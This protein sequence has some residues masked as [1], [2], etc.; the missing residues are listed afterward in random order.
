MSEVQT[1]PNLQLLNDGY[2]VLG[3]LRS[4]AHARTY[5]AR[6]REDGSEVII[7]VAGAPKGGENNALNHFAADTQLLSKLSHPLMPKVIEGRWV[8]KD[9]FAVVSERHPGSTLDELLARGEKFSPPRIAGILQDVNTV[10]E[11]ARSNGVVHR[12]VSPD[13]LSFERDTNRVLL[14]L[15]PTAVPLEGVPDASA[16]ARTIGMLSWSMLAGKEFTEGQSLSEL[17]PNLAK[18]VVDETD[19][20]VRSTSGGTVPDV[21][22]YVAVVAAADALRSGELEIAE[23]QAQIAEERRAELAQFAAEQ[24]ASAL[25]NKEL[26]EQLANERR[27]FEAKMADEEA[28][29]AA[30][31]AEFAA[32]KASEESQ[33]SVERTQFE[34]ERLELEQARVAFEQK[35]AEREAELTAKHAAVDRLRAEEGKRIDAAIAAAV[36]TVAATAVITPVED[37]LSEAWKSGSGQAEPKA[38]VGET[39]RQ[40]S[41]GLG[42]QDVVTTGGNGRRP[43]WAMPAVAVA[44][45]LLLVG[46]FAAT[47][48]E[49][50]SPGAVAVGKST[51]VPTAPATNVRSTP[52]GGFMTQSAGGTVAAPPVGPPLAPQSTAQVTAAV[53]PNASIAPVG[54]AAAAGAAPG[55]AQTATPDSATLARQRNALAAGLVKPKPKPKASA[56]NAAADSTRG[57]SFSAEADAIRRADAARRDSA[58]RRDTTPRARPDTTVTAR[59]DTLLHR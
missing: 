44:L 32:L 6:R 55:T 38:W 4:G 1:A 52:Q 26:E 10:L 30:V 37:D 7:S 23:L 9:Q 42:E 27:E 39:V 24:Q 8:G 34:Q 19:S 53:Q 41:V 59:P 43:G 48:R 50:A 14:S 58:A 45:V 31:K 40:H 21:L 36:E 56:R 47:H 2:E 18:R 29:L 33:F 15:E 49:G 17:R 16:D 57:G 11:W 3:E 13:S 25:R 51:I 54:A 35:V 46:I 5:M 28:Q 12:G 22:T 20:M